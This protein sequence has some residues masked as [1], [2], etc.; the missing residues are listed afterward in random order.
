MAEAYAR[1]LATEAVSGGTE[2]SVARQVLR[3]W[4]TPAAG[5]VVARLA[6]DRLAT[7]PEDVRLWFGLVGPRG[8]EL[9]QALLLAVAEAVVAAPDATRIAAL[10][11]LLQ[12]EPPGTST[13]DPA[14]HRLFLTNPAAGSRV[15][16]GSAVSITIGTRPAHPCP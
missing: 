16:L 14:L 13:T 8:S 9:A 3:D 11:G 5:R 10:A 12:E 6:Y 4:W 15:S 7:R 2:S 1:F